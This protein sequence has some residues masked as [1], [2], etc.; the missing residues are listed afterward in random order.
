[1]PNVIET[2]LPMVCKT[3]EYAPIGTNLGLLYLIWALIS[4][5]FL[6]SRGGIFPALAQLG[7]PKAAVRRSWAALNKGGWQI[8][9]LIVAWREQVETAGRWQAVRVDGYRV[10]AGDMSASCFYRKLE[11]Q[12]NRRSH[13]I[14]IYPSF[15]LATDNSMPDSRLLFG[16]LGD[17]L[18][19]S[20]C[21][22]T[23]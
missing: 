20:C 1:M 22:F 19:G 11:F 3:V 4:G 15:R 17:T 13:A 18:S 21:V 9:K 8:G 10:K 2:V 6:E 14:P 23:V 5:Q 7:L 12:S 16:I